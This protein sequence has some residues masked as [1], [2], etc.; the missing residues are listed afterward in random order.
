MAT[1]TQAR[2]EEVNLQSAGVLVMEAAKLLRVLD[3]QN[4]PVGNTAERAALKRDL[5][6]LSDVLA[7][8]SSEVRAQY[9][10]VNGRPDI[11]ESL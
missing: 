3:K 8:A 1:D 11:L 6:Y 5:V 4:P 2:P 9:H 7:R 10:A